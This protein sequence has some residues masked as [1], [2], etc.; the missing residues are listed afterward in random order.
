MKPYFNH[1]QKEITK[2]SPNLT[3][4]MP[5]C[6]FSMDPNQQ[7]VVDPLYMSSYVS[8]ARTHGTIL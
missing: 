5:L 6:G 3:T 7:Y 1:L 8:K 2:I 4:I